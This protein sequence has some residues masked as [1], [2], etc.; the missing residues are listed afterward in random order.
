MISIK[1]GKFVDNFDAYENKF[2]VIL[3]NCKETRHFF[4]PKCCLNWF[5]GIVEHDLVM[6]LMNS[7][8]A[9]RGVPS[10]LSS[11]PC[12]AVSSEVEQKWHIFFSKHLGSW[13]E[14]LSLSL[15]LGSHHV[16]GERECWVEKDRLWENFLGPLLMAGKELGSPPPL[17][18][19]S[20][21]CD[22]ACAQCSCGPPHALSECWLGWRTC[23]EEPAGD[24][25]SLVCGCRG[26]GDRTAR[27]L[28]AVSCCMFCQFN[29][30]RSRAWGPVAALASSSSSSGAP[31]DKPLSGPPRALNLVIFAVL[32]WT[33]LCPF[34]SLEALAGHSA[35]LCWG[36][37]SGNTQNVPYHLHTSRFDSAL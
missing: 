28:S 20:A 31:T 4:P 3:P 19:L 11:P 37:D 22:P 5:L 6:L 1:L 12:P 16:A 13:C 10:V 36:S 26:L 21:Y 9:V 32:N 27:L 25:P 17:P 2:T 8:C 14:I 23:W 34:H 29:S 15:R 35:R 24:K 33:C 7:C 18:W 30:C